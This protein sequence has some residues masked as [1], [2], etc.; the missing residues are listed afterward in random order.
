MN[1][2]EEP[3]SKAHDRASFG[4]GD[5]ALDDYL[6]R[7]ARQNH[8]SGLAK[9][10]VAIEDISLK[11]LGFYSLSP[12]EID[13]NRVPDQVTRGMSRYNIPGFRLGRLAVSLTAQGQ[14]LGGQLLMAAVRRCVLAA[15]EVG[16]TI[17]II[18]AKNEAVADWYAKFGASPLKDKPL[19]LVLPLA[20]F[21]KMLQETGKI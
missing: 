14:G 17:L 6:H 3:I 13:H 19:T 18:D 2:F 20:S 10:F 5:A 11:I 12:A 8:I 9:T 15:G 4:C 21:T 7:H 1:W 16:G